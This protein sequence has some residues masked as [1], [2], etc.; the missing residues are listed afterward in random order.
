MK[1]NSL[2]CVWLFATLELYSPWNSPGQ[3]T[4]VGSHSLPQGIFPMQGSNPGL[5]HC[6]WILY[7]LSQ[8]RSPRILEWVV[9]LFSIGSSQPRGQTR[10]SCIASRCFTVWPTREIYHSLDIYK[11]SV[12]FRQVSFKKHGLHLLFMNQFVECLICATKEE[13]NA[14]NSIKTISI[15]WKN[16]THIKKKIGYIR[17]SNLGSILH[18]AYII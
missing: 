14:G 6:R 13:E 9:F 8:Q 2:S 7:Q 15:G 5:P 3:N 4:G 17:N 1:W 16:H 12:G 10:V 11:I 18:L